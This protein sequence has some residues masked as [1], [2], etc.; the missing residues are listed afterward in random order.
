MTEK[1]LVHI[2]SDSQETTIK[3]IVD[4]TFMIEVK[5]KNNSFKFLCDNV[6]VSE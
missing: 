5:T 4:N 1:S 3:H 2:V 6:R